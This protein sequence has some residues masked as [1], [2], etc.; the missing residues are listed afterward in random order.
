MQSSQA[1]P[2]PLRWANPCRQTSTF[3]TE[4]GDFWPPAPPHAA[5]KPDL[6]QCRRPREPQS[7]HHEPKCASR[8][9]IRAPPESQDLP[10]PEK[11]MKK[12]RFHDVCK[13]APGWSWDALLAPRVLRMGSQVPQKGHH[14][15][16]KLPFEIP[17]WVQIVENSTLRAPMVPRR[18]QGIQ[19]EPKS[20][21]RPPKLSENP[22]N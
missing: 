21:P 11:T 20:D 6:G 15:F 13:V 16:Q 19:T 1:K 5:Q 4:Q 22:P 3:T 2:P 10:K 7:A 9:P 8:H 14:R 18:A 12:Q 17:K